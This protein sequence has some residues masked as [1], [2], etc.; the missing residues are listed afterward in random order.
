MIALYCEPQ[1]MR[2]RL[3]RLLPANQCR[4]VDSRGEFQR[5][6]LR[7]GT[8]VFGTLKCRRADAGWLARLV[9]DSRHVTCTA[10][11]PLSLTNLQSL[12]PFLSDRLKVVW[13]EEA[14]AELRDFGN[15]TQAGHDNPLHRLADGILAFRELSPVAKRALVEI[16]CPMPP[17]SNDLPLRPAPPRNMDDLASRVHHSISG[18][19][20]HWREQVP[21][22][23]T[24]RKLMEWAL[25]IWA[26]GDRVF[27]SAAARA[28][29]MGI[30][31]RTLE[32]ISSRLMGCRISEALQDPAG[33]HHRF[34]EWLDGVLELPLDSL[35]RDTGLM[36]RT[37][38]PGDRP[39]ANKKLP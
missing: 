6:L 7:F 14:R 31:P 15:R 29:Y 20:A 32:R 9:D 10:V 18:I 24:P 13:L 4:R 33:V 27:R 22:R 5:A 35:V 34:E 17:Q 38:G 23:C 3:Q 37:G 11:V 30:H 1:A 16:C 36:G 12:R 2:G 21:L 39:V 28:R 19:R 8:G 26:A 25:L